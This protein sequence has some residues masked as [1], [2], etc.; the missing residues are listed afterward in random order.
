MC[1]ERLWPEKRSGVAAKILAEHRRERRVGRG[2]TLC[3]DPAYA[4]EWA[5]GDGGLGQ[6]RLADAGLSDQQPQAALTIA[7]AGEDLP[8]LFELAFATEHGIAPSHSAESRRRRPAGKP[9]GASVHCSAVRD[10]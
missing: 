9:T 1:N 2:A 6:T 4:I 3:G 5:G 8:E 7:G 10:R